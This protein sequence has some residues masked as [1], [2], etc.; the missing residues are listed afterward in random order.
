MQP[1]SKFLAAGCKYFFEV[2]CKIAN[3]FDMI[4][5]MP[6]ATNFKSAGPP[7]ADL[8]DRVDGI[9]NEKRFQRMLIDRG[10][11]RSI[12]PS[13]SWPLPF[14]LSLNEHCPCCGINANAIGNPL[15]HFVA[16]WK[17]GRRWFDGEKNDPRVFPEMYRTAP[18]PRGYIVTTMFGP[19]NPYLKLLGDVQGKDSDINR[20]LQINRDRQHRRETL[21]L[22]RGLAARL[23]AYTGYQVYMQ[24]T[25]DASTVCNRTRQS[26]WITTTCRAADILHQPTGNNTSAAV[27]LEVC[28]MHLQEATADRWGIDTFRMYAGCDGVDGAMKDARYKLRHVADKWSWLWPTQ[29]EDY[30]RRADGIK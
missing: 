17:D 18:R 28:Q 24:L 23:Q 26:F 19:E 20:K 21:A 15:P 2:R 10:V 13:C 12:C 5:S 30:T 3:P 1:A 29:L 11:V 7:N 27:I 6:H 25:E 9:E 22:Y 16:W 8:H 14:E 4:E